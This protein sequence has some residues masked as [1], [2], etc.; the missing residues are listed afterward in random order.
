MRSVSSWEVSMGSES[1]IVG[2]R[3]GL[4]VV[5]RSVSLGAVVAFRG[6]A[7]GGRWSTYVRCCLL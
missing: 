7:R 1:R 2:G 4:G 3:V 5:R 6:A